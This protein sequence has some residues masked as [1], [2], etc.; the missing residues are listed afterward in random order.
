M[1]PPIKADAAGAW[2][3]RRAD[4]TARWLWQQ[5]WLQGVRHVASPNHDQR[6]AGVAPWLVVVHAISLPPDCFGGAAVMAL[7]TNTLDPQAHPYFRE[8]AGLRVSA[9]FFIRRQGEV[10]Q[11]VSADDRAWH[12]GVSCWRGQTACNDFSVGIELEGCDTRPFEPVQYTQLN[13]LLA[14]LRQRYP[15]R[16]VVGHADIAPGRKTDPGPYF[17]WTQ[18]CRPAAEDA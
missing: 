1:M 9:H 17:D 14:A 12:A 4:V 6:P 2:S 15:I 16:E 11:L 8:I 18:V 13:R 7:F 10:L 5:G 3:E